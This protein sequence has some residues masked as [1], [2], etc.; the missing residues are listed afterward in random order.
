MKRA[1]LLLALLP[2]IVSQTSSAQDAG[3]P[4]ATTG[5]FFALSVSDLAA[6]GKWYREK[7]GLRVV[8]QPPQ[9]TE[10]SVMVLEGGGLIVELLQH[11]AARPMTSAAP[12]VRESYQV[13]GLFKAG[14][15]VEDFDRT[16]A[17]LRARGVEIAIGP[18]PRTSTQRANAIVKDNAGN[19]IQFFG[20]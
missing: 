11:A 16:I 10:A 9:S 4:F 8:L 7:F 14:L 18:F 15:I 17:A 3:P 1:I 5:A 13:H 12:G 19:M 20:R 2:G 6:S